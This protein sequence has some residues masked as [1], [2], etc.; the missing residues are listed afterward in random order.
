M[1]ALSSPGPIN[2][3]LYERCHPPSVR[4]ALFDMVS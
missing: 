4:D 2:P 1:L 3:G